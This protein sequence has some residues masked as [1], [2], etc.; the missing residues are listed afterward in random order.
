MSLVAFWQGI[1]ILNAI[2]EDILATK[3]GYS[4]IVNTVFVL[5]HATCSL[6]QLLCDLRSVIGRV[7][8][9][10]CLICWLLFEAFVGQHFEQ[11]CLEFLLEQLLLI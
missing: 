4:L 3:F 2:I 6:A 11:A 5:D 7:H 8:F 9:L 1:V 10:A